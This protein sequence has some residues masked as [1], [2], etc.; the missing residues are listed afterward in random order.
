MKRL[1]LSLLATLLACAGTWAARALCIPFTVVQPDGTTL[2]IT[3]NGDEHLSWLTTTD[4]TLVVEKDKSYYVAAISDQGKLTATS[5]LAHHCDMRSE[6][7]RIACEMQQQRKALFFQRVEHVG[8]AARRAQVTNTKYFP[9]TGTPRCLVILANYEDNQ[10]SSN[11]PLTQFK[12]YFSGEV[13]EDLG[14]NESK[15]LLSVQ[16]YFE[17]SS[18]G[19][20]K[21]QFD[22]VGPVTL[23]QK[24]AYYGKNESDGYDTL[25][26]DMCVDAVN[27]V[28]DFVD[29]RQ[30]DNNNDGKAELVC[31]IYAGY[32]ESVSGNP[33][34]TIWPKCGEQNI[35]TADGIS[36]SFFNCSPE[37]FRLSDGNNINGIGLFTHEFSHGLGLPDLYAKDSQAYINN[38]SPE[39]WDL[40]DYGEYANNG[41]AP[42]PYTVWEQEAMGW[43][44]VE[45]LTESQEN[46][47]IEPL[48]NGGKAYKFNNSANSEEWFMIENVQPRNTTDQTLGFSYGHGL[49]VWHIAYA[50]SS[51]AMS[52]YPNNSPNKPRVCI[53]PADGLVI[54]GYLFG[55]GKPY[56][57]NEYTSSLRGDPFPGTSNNPTLSSDQALPNYKFYN[58]QA[59]PVFQLKNISEDSDS[60]IV[61]FDFDN[62][63]PTAIRSIE[64]TPT[65]H[66]YYTLDGRRLS[67]EPTRHGLY[68]RNGKKV[69]R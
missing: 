20:F 48:I 45:K 16:R 36:V 18:H 5:L 54:N 15:N 53:V 60:R 22:V 68:I 59:T 44:E 65:S 10:F 25:F 64:D 19:K 57:Q 4:G 14:H 62:G 52:D 38:Q 27:A 13:Q 8:E 23:P 37:L 26:Y 50:K 1:I 35:G 49:L 42:V 21:P 2:V 51:V 34:E 17:Q 32:G 28:D 9:H 55:D 6:Q 46:I 56:S 61:T 33:S 69:R 12:Q 39:F 31:I 43:I 3:L 11:D 63:T 41:Y 67:S 24:M 7:E 58:G 40:M 47:Q 30:Y 29:F 66:H